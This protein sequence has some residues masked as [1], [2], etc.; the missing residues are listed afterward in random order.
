MWKPLRT[1]ALL[2]ASGTLA[3]T[4]HAAPE[5]EITYS[6]V[7]GDT[8]YDL[9][10]D[11]LTSTDAVQEIQRLNSISNPRR[12]QIGQKLRLP[13]RLL[14]FEPVALDLRSFSGPVSLEQ[15]GQEIDTKLGQALREG[16]LISTGNNGFA[17]IAGDGATLVS[18]PSNSRIQIIDARRYLINDKIDIQIKVLT[19]RGE[20]RA[21]KIEGDAR[22]RVGTPIAVTAVRGTEFRVAH[23]EELASSLT[24]VVEGSVGVTQGEQSVE[25]DAGFGVAAKATGLGGNEQLLAAP[26]LVDAGRIQTEA[27]VNFAIDELQGAAGYR[28]QIARDAGFV[29]VIDQVVSRVTNASFTDLDDG[30]YFIRTRAVSQSGLEGLSEVSS[31]RRK[32]LGSEAGT[33]QSPIAD[34]FK[35]AWRVQGEG[36]SYSAFQLWNSDNP[37]NLLVDEVGLQQSAVLVGSLEPGTYNWRVATFQIDDGDTIKVWGPTQELSVTE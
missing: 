37:S 28:T 19:G 12:L 30:R 3:T 33:E 29:E 31:F 20:V 35:F 25:T 14:K 11:Y 16:T 32:R 23:L 1:S 26:E 10:E 2:I 15:N 17:A 24:E 18:V 4:A 27:S 6:V 5:G 8:L 34:A 36:K 7:V 22:F 21:P 13:R 9:S